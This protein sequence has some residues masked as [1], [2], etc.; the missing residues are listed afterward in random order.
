[1]DTVVGQFPDMFTAAALRNPVIA[2][3]EISTSDIPDWYYNEFG[4]NYLPALLS[5]P[6][7]TVINSKTKH[8][9]S[10]TGNLRDSLWMSPSTYNDLQSSSP[11]AHVKNVKADILL[12][13]GGSDLRVAPTQGIGYYHALRACGAVSAEHSSAV[14]D[15]HR[16]RVEML[17]FEGERHSLEGVEASRVVWECTLDWFQKVRK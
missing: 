3:A 4:F 2:S 14:A 16:P 11:I 9:S 17:W 8:L 6:Q 10:P 1:M 7:Y 12:F 13:I 15:I 5:Q